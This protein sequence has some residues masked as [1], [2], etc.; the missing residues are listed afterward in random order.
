MLAQ[1]C[2]GYIAE[3]LIDRAA[4]VPRGKL[5]RIV[6]AARLPGLA[7]GNE[8]DGLIPVAQVG[9]ETHRGSVM[10]GCGTW[11]IS[12]AGLRLVR[13]AEKRFEQARAAER[14]NHIESVKLLPGPIV[15]SRLIA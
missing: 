14:V 9:D 1:T 5:I 4:L 7:A 2:F 6:L 10:F 12:C 15:D 3:R 11:A 8:H 13:D